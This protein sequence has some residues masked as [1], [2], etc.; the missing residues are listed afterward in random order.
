M[1]EGQYK[2]PDGSFYDGIWKLGKKHG[3]G[4][5]IYPNGKKDIGLFKKD[6]FVGKGKT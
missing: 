5:Y 4:T 2:Y 3:L 6:K 1:V